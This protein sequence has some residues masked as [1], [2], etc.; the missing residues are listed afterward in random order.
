MSTELIERARTGIAERVA[1]VAE[2]QRARAVAQSLQPGLIYQTDAD[3]AAGADQAGMLVIGQ[4]ALKAAKDAAL[5][6]PKAMVEAIN[7]VCRPIEDELARARTT[8]DTA[9]LAFDRQKVLEMRRREAAAAEAARLEAERIQN[10]QQEQIAAA[11]AAGL[12]EE[13]VAEIAAAAEEVVPLEHA[14]ETKPPE[15]ITRGGIAKQTVRRVPKAE[16][17]DMTKVPKHLVDLRLS[18]AW[19][20]ARV[21]IRRE[22]MADPSVGRENGVVYQGVRYFYE[23]SVTTSGATR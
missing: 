5:Q 14:V 20:E 19:A 10:E 23:E 13:Q 21:A 16:I 1:Q 8:V 18:D 12:S 9:K 4:R 3:A 6:I 22:Q 11:R 2:V 7:G 17:E 15:R